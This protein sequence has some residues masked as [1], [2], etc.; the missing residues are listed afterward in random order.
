MAWRLVPLYEEEE[1]LI[2]APSLRYRQRQGKTAF[3]ESAPLTVKREAS[4]AEL[5]STY[6]FLG[7]HVHETT[8]PAIRDLW[9]N[10]GF[11]VE[12]F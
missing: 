4:D 5:H 6:V 12:E 8:D 7:G 1:Y 9:L 11:E 3:G 10:S 2:A